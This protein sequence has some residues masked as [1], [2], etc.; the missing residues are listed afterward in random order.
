MIRYFTFY[1]SLSFLLYVYLG[2]PVLLW[3]WRGLGR[4]SLVKPTSEANTN[5]VVLSLQK[6]W[7]PSVTIIVAAY[8]E[9]AAPFEW[10]KVNFR[11]KTP[12]G[13][14]SDLCK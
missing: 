8:N 4:R 7:E 12:A 6:K 9:E 10:T 3:F 1:L 13:K 5:S 11:A 14:Y 2:Y